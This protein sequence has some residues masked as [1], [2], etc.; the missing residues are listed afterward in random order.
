MNFTEESLTSLGQS[1]VAVM[2]VIL[3]ITA[4]FTITMLVFVS[5][6]LV[7]LYLLALFFY[8]EMTYNHIVF[9]LIIISLGLSVDY[10]A[11]IA[12]CYLTINP[13]DSMTD[14]TER[15][16]YKIER[17]LGQIGSSVFHGGFSTFLAVMTLSPSKFYG[18]MVFFRAL[19][20]I[21]IFG[22]ANGFILLPVLLSY[23]GPTDNIDDD[24]QTE[25]V[26]VKS[27]KRCWCIDKGEDE[28][29]SSDYDDGDLSDYTP[30]NA[31]D[32]TNQNETGGN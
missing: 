32:S 28:L 25:E 17:A 11:H 7:D 8:W 18:F 9:L 29:S 15:R 16:K 31:A 6:A 20:G 23:F 3:F 19:F 30:K 5:V 22:M 10:T 12:H 27:N 14:K 4:N 2:V 13:P 21:V 24:D 26:K 1:L